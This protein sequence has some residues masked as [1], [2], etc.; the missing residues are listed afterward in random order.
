M[1]E[2]DFN[3]EMYNYFLTFSIGPFVMKRSP[4]I[5]MMSLGVF[6]YLNEAAAAAHYS[7]DLLSVCL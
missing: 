1:K 4:N 3:K 2:T 6:K 7:P 5:K